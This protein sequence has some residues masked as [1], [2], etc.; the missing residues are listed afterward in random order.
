MRQSPLEK[1]IV[2]G[3]LKV[4]RDLGWWA[5]K[6]HGSQF[7][8]VGLPDVLV[9]KDGKAAWMEAKRP[10]QVPTKIQEHRMRELAAAGC[11]V[12]VVCSAAEA[13]DFLEACE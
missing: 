3:V 1:T 5:M 8:V 6:N 10:G 9:I 13:R 4:A 2:N 7:S 12:A 11:P